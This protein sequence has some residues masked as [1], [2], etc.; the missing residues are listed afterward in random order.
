VCKSTSKVLAFMVNFTLHPAIL[1]GKDWLYSRDYI[2]Y[3]TIK[4]QE[5]YG[6]ETV[7]WFSNGAEGNINHLNYKDHHQ[8]RGFE[9]A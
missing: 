9:E 2:H 5:A 7:V 6:S 8:K 4:L 1:V 3:L